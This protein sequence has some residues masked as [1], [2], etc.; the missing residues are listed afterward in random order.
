MKR[1]GLGDE[2]MMHAHPPIQV[3]TTEIPKEPINPKRDGLSSRLFWGELNVSFDRLFCFRNHPGGCEGQLVFLFIH[4]H[5][6][7][8]AVL[9]LAA[10]QFH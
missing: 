6:Y 5:L 9:E 8:R 7:G 10:K 1:S 4:I 2:R 3:P